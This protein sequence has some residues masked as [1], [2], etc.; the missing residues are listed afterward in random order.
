MSKEA[1]T[2]KILFCCY[3]NFG[4]NKLVRLPLH[5]DTQLNGTQNNN[6]QHKDTVV[7]AAF[8]FFETSKLWA[9]IMYIL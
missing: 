7:N 2:Y 6:T 9:L 3:L 4:G 1:I 5:H 8:L